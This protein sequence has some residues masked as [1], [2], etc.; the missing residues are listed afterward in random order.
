MIP[1]KHV[2][3]ELYIKSQEQVSELIALL[4]KS[5]NQID[6]LIKIVIKTDPILKNDPE[7]FVKR[8][9]DYIRNSTAYEKLSK[10][11][12]IIIHI[13]PEGFQDSIKIEFKQIKKD[14]IVPKIYPHR[15][16]GADYCFNYDG[17]M[18][19][20]ADETIQFYNQILRNGS[21]E[22]LASLSTKHGEPKIYEAYLLEDLSKVIF[23]GIDALNEVFHTEKFNVYI[24]LSHVNKVKISRNSGYYGP[25]RIENLYLPAIELSK[26]KSIDE[27]KA[28]LKYSI[29]LI[30]QSCNTR[31][32]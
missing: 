22:S 19:Y 10:D 21:F 7:I 6:E 32:L 17:F 5:N 11:P 30:Y 12:A 29:D 31:Y 4:K 15:Y 24:S 28:A 20:Y 9:I 1:D 27:I 25:F 8:R 26:S 16:S 23:N 18:V 14:D 13:I 3:E 2:Y